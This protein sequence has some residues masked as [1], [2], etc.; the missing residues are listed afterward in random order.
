MPIDTDDLTDKKYN[1]IIA[2][3]EKFNHD[4]TLQ[5]GL[6]SYS[7]KDEDAFVAASKKLIEKMLKYNK[8]NLADIFFDNAPPMADFHVALH[9]ILTNIENL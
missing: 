5:F 1:A 8:A 4:P 7:C 3:A 6:L 2:E 9:Q